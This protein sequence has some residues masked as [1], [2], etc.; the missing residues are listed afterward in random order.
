M[1]TRLTPPPPPPS[2][3]PPSLLPPSSLP[4]PPPPNPLSPRK[5]WDICNAETTDCATAYIEYEKTIKHE[6]IQPVKE[7]LEMMRV[8]KRKLMKDETEAAA[9]LASVKK[10]KVAA[11][12]KHAK[13]C[14]DYEHA[15]MVYKEYEAALQRE[16]GEEKG[17]AGSGDAGGAAAA[18]AGAGG[19]AAGANGGAAFE[20]QT[21]AEDGGDANAATPPVPARRTHHS[22]SASS[23]SSSG[24][25]ASMTNFF[26]SSTRGMFGGICELA[27]AEG[28]W[29]GSIEMRE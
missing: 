14:K 18:G 29:R 11:E 10:K 5:V 1:G 24:R 20:G 6:A 19:A 13:L 15:Q 7:L 28:M 16:M 9:I 27:W 8:R 21:I 25:P 12:K 23:I 4:P 3:P 26:R 2:L 17:Q 22:S